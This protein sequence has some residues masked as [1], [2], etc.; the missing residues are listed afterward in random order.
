[1]SKLPYLGRAPAALRRHRTVLPPG[2]KLAGNTVGLNMYRADVLGLVPLSGS[3]LFINIDGLDDAD[4]T[5]GRWMAQ[6]WYG[7][8]P[9]PTAFRT[10]LGYPVELGV[11]RLEHEGNRIHAILNRGGDTLIDATIALKEGGPKP[12]GAFLNYPV[13][14]QNLSAAAASSAKSNFAVNRIPFSGELTAA[15][16][17]SLEFHF[18]NSDAVKALQPKRLLDAF[19]VK[20]SGFLRGPDLSPRELAA[21]R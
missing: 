12:V 2:L 14:R 20:G 15:S 18:G 4:G 6:G 7:P 9:V 16:P 11:T 8:E 5:K 3:Y 10:Q 1:M 13:S 17:V 21:L 19:S